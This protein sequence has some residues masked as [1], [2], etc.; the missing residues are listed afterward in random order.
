MAT[1]YLVLGAG[2]QGVAAA[3][4]F[5]RF[6]D[7]NTIVLADADEK[8]ARDGAERVN[9]LLSRK[10]VQARQADVT[11]EAA[12]ASLLEEADLCL[13]A[14]PYFFNITLT[15][16]AVENACSFCDLGGNTDVVFR[17]HDFPTRQKQRG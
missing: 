14:V 9:R 1:N 16:L 17:Q 13:S 3:F 11:D 6:G 7:A 5:G 8:P 12:I 10:L 4:D 15:K 2:M